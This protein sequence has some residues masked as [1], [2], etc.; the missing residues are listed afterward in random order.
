MN[1]LDTTTKRIFVIAVSV[2]MVLLSLSAFVYTIQRATAGPK[3]FP[4][5]YQPAAVG[6]GI[7]NNT[8]YYMTWEPTGFGP[9]GGVYIQKSIQIQH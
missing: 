9:S 2:S 6:L 5:V 1:N 4:V 7:I 8:G 3:S